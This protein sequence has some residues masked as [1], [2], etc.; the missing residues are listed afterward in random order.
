ME[1]ACQSVCQPA[2]Q[3]ACQP[4]CQ[5]ACQPACQ[6]ANQ[7]RIR[8]IHVCIFSCG[9]SFHACSHT[10]TASVWFL[11]A[12]FLVVLCFIQGQAAS[13]ALRSGEFPHQSSC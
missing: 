10:L 5:S 9:R 4:V 13:I 6:S 1:S 3:S 8:S 7:M 2:C 12:S 11:G